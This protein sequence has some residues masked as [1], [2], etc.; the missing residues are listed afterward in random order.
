MSEHQSSRK[1]IA[2]PPKPSAE[3]W[4]RQGGDVTPPA[5]SKLKRLTLDLPET[6]H[7]AIKLRAVADGS[8]IVDMLRTLLEREY[9]SPR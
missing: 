4:V 7:R 6:L 8:S 2:I 3:Q 1:A 5:P 9:G